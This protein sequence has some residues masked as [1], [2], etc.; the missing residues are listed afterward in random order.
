MLRI[1]LRGLISRWEDREKTMSAGIR[2][3]KTNRAKMELYNQWAATERSRRELQ[4]LLDEMA[5]REAGPARG[6]KR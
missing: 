5:V 2:R 1:A 6:R 4:N 3:L